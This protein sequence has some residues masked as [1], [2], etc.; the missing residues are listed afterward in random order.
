MPQPSVFCD[1]LLI[2]FGQAPWRIA[3]ASPCDG[4]GTAF[5]RVDRAVRAGAVRGGPGVAQWTGISFQ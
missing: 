4:G 2:L 1:K 3:A 5:E